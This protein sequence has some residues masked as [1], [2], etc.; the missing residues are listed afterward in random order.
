M[1]GVFFMSAS[2]EAQ[3]RSVV[4]ENFQSN[5]RYWFVG[6]LGYAQTTIRHDHSIQLFRYKEI[7]L[8]QLEI[9]TE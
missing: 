4:A 6:D 8:P 5:S 7:F 3:E 2:L 9:R 1:V